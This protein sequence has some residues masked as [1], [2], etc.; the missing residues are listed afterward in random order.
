[1]RRHLTSLTVAGVGVRQL[2]ALAVVAERTVR[3][4]LHGTRT[5]LLAS[6]AGRLLALRPILAPGQVVESS[7]AAALLRALL[8]EGYTRS[9]MARGLGI[10]DSSLRRILTAPTPRMRVRVALRTHALA[11]AL[12]GNEADAW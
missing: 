8:D 3:D 11:E 10:D 6:T 5:R 9:Q 4:T 1:M 12:L 2:A 7:D